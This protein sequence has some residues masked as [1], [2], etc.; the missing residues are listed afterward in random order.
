M[1]ANVQITG[2]NG[3]TTTGRAFLDSGSTVTLVSSNIKEKLALK[4]VG[5]NLC[6][7]GVAEFQAKESNPLVELTLTSSFDK[8]WKKNITAVAMPNVVRNLPLKDASVA[9]KMSHL[10][11]IHLAD[12]LYHQPGPIDLLLGQDVFTHLFLPGRLEGPPETPVA[13]KTVF[14]WSIMGLYN[15]PQPTQAITA[16]AFSVSTD[17]AT[18]ASDSELDKHKKTEENQSQEKRSP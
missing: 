16:S 10:Q 3:I 11:E 12:P 8:K 17:L 4:P 14:G 15:Q 2:T 6:V 18:Q 5:E 13:W 9:R 7:D 1:T